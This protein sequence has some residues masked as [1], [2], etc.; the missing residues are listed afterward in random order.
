M[1]LP[2]SETQRNIG[3]VTWFLDP[4][5]FEEVPGRRIYSTQ[6]MW[7][8]IKD[9]TVTPTKDT[10][11]NVSLNLLVALNRNSNNFT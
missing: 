8:P 1:K 9:I 10:K 6:E 11:M 5:L 7:L 3:S 2:T 4:K